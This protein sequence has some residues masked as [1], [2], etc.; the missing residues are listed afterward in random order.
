M[1]EATVKH[2]SCLYESYMMGS[3]VRKNLLTEWGTSVTSEIKE[4]QKETVGLAAGSSPD[5]HAESQAELP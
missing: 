5:A 3:R 1:T 2:R 4:T